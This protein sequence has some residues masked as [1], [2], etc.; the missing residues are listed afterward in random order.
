MNPLSAA[1]MSLYSIICKEVYDCGQDRSLCAL[2]LSPSL[3]PVMADF[4]L[5]VQNCVQTLSGLGDLECGKSINSQGKVF[6]NETCV[7]MYKYLYQ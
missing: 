3:L 5:K 6:N 2:Q 1:R 4:G 7:S